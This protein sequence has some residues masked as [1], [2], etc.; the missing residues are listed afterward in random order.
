MNYLN[1]LK[2]YLAFFLAA[3]SII[4]FFLSLELSWFLAAV[5]W[6]VIS[7]N[8]LKGAEITK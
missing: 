5:P 4:G 1:K 6:S 7:L 3:Y 8:Y 2:E